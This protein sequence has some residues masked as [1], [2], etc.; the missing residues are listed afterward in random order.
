MASNN[1]NKHFIYPPTSVL[2]TSLSTS[3]DTGSLVVSGGI[4]I[5]NTLNIQNSIGSL[6][7]MYS[8]DT[9]GASSMSTNVKTMNN[10]IR[11]S[12][13]NANN[14]VSTWTLRTTSINQWWDVCWSPEL[15]IFVAVA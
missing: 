15:G 4:G 8:R 7:Y 9:V 10:R 12:R 1:T 3:S 6:G 14:C 13:A 2:N 11:T 5:S